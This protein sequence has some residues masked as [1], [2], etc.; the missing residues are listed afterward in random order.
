ME[1]KMEVLKAQGGN[2]EL[3]CPAAARQGCCYLNIK[4]ALDQFQRILLTGF[5]STS[6]QELTLSQVCKSK[7]LD[8]SNI[9][10]GQVLGKKSAHGGL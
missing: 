1:T 9:T 8:C 10:Q 3:C 6:Q 4:V 5:F 7:A 2:S